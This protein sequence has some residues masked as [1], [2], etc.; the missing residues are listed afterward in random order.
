MREGRTP[1]ARVIIVHVRCYG[2]YLFKREDERERRTPDLLH[3]DYKRGV[4]DRETSSKEI[5]G[6]TNEKG[7]YPD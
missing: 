6:E 3:V 5:S 2:K 4:S 1:R 7:W